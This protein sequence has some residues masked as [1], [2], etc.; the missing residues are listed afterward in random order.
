MSPLR[1]RLRSLASRSTAAAVAF[2]VLASAASAT[3]GE[4]TAPPAANQAQ[5]KDVARLLDKAVER[6][7]AGDLEAARESFDAAWRLQKD[8]TIASNLADVEIKLARYRDAAEH[9][10]YCI[11]HATDESA[12]KE[13][14]RRLV[15]CRRFV[16][17]VT[18]SVDPPAATLLVDGATAGQA[19]LDGELWLE[20]GTHTLR[21]QQQGRSSPEKTVKVA[22][23]EDIRVELKLG[24]NAVAPA[25]ALS[26]TENRPASSAAPP[27]KVASGRHVDTSASADG[28]LKFYSLVGGSALGAAAIGAGLLWTFSANS[29]EDSAN[30]LL[31]QVKA[32]GDPG[33]AG[34][35][36]SCTGAAGLPPAKC[37]DLKQARESVDRS[38]NLATGAFIVG[39]VLIAG[40]VSAYFLWPEQQEP[41]KRSALRFVPWSA[42][43]ANG[44]QLSGT[45]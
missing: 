4:Q 12:R 14:E 21:A 32:E 36:S 41:T 28:D 7:A 22:S 42:G 33:L 44:V 40:T 24:P 26:A 30:A 10:S 11:H 45:F 39:G 23:G 5:I 6:Y 3:A 9:L 13:A 35:D 19:P 29:D 8:V 18:V 2:A 43:K 38:R 31:T 20:P 34:T 17:S 16:G 27:K 25:A 37:G 1:L 15:E